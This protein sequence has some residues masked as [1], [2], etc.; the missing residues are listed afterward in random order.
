[1]ITNNN[2]PL[3]TNSIKKTVFILSVIPSVIFSIFLFSSIGDNLITRILWG[4][5]AMST[6]FFQTLK[7]REFH[8]TK[9]SK[10]YN[11]LAVYLICTFVSIMGTVGAGYSAIQKTKLSNIDN[12]S[13]IEIIEL[14]IKDFENNKTKDAINKVL[15]SKDLNQ[16]AAI[17]LIKQQSKL[18]NYDDLKILKEKRSMLLKKE[19][20]IVS[21][22]SGLANIFKIS[23]ETMSFIFLIFSAILLELMVYGSSDFNGKI[24]EF[25]KQKEKQVVKEKKSGQLFLKRLG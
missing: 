4:I 10:R 17:N 8:N 22:I 24:F 12:T 14:Q 3:R 1:M 13:E 6:V 15:E 9:K 16:W 25:K 5:V 18:N 2:L 21:S 19:S 23:V 20:G 7:L 11:H